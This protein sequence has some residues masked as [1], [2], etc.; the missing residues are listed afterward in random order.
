MQGGTGWRTRLETGAKAATEGAPAA[1]VA[2]EDS[3][4]RGPGVLDFAEVRGR[5]GQV[6]VAVSAV[7]GHSLEVAVFRRPELVRAVF[8]V[9]NGVQE[10]VVCL[11]ALEETE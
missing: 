7:L 6:A 9:D 2:Q 11:S 5:C 10:V 4:I 3:C 1:V 8:D